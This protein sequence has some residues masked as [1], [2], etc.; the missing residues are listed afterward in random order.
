[1]NFTKMHGLGNDFV[2]VAEFSSVPDRIDS[3]AQSVCDR[4][5]G[6]GADGLVLILPHERADFA[7]RIFNADGTEAEQCGNAVR[8]V[9]KYVFD[10]QL[11]DKEEILLE[12]RVGIQRLK[13][14]IERGEVAQVTVDMGEPKLAG[15]EI[16]TQVE[17]ERVIDHPISVAD[18]EF[19]FTAVSMGNPHAVIFVESLESVRLH[20][21]G[22]QIETNLLFPRRTNVEFVQVHGPD[23]VT[24]RVWERGCGETLACGSGACAV[25]VAGVLNGRTSRNAVVHL[26]GGDLQIEWRESDNRVYMTGPSRIVFEGVY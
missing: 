8:C 5:F 9:A 17:A 23:E 12:T 22:P 15:R 19:R 25:V 24:M 4:H 26:Q 14:V 2:V 16:P 7:M 11:T 3:L 13:L 1:M 21:A 18:G 6:I 20:Q 10:K